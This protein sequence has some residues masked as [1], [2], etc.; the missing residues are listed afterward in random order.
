MILV[1]TEPEPSFRE[2]IEGLCE[3][4]VE[5]FHNSIGSSLA[6]SRAEKYSDCRIAAI[7]KKFP[8]EKSFDSQFQ[9]A[10]T[11]P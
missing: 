2:C 1:M 5:E 4:P 8:P 3:P 9:D 11:K 7:G 6:S 10:H